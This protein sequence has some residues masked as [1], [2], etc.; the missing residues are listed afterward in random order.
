MKKRDPVELL[1]NLVELHGSQARVARLLGVSPQYLN[2]VL[3]Q[4]RDPGPKILDA[5]KLERVTTYREKAK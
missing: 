4:E 3:L 2:D 1:E 5:L